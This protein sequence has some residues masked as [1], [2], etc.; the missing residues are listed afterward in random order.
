[1]DAPAPVRKV[2][3]EP[4]VSVLYN[5]AAKALAPRILFWFEATEESKYLAHRLPLYTNGPVIFV[6][7]DGV[8]PEAIIESAKRDGK[9][10]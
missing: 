10:S 4:N 3:Y 5:W 8:S 1:V 2:V 9:K 6:I 7:R